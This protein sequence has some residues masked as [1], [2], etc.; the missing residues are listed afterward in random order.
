MIEERTPQGAKARA[1]ILAALV[2]AGYPRA[3]PAVLQPADVFL[4]MAGEDIRG[5][6]FLTTDPS[7]TEFCLRPEFTIP[8][9]RDYLASPQAGRAASFSY[10]GSVF[11]QRPGAPPETAQA[12]LEDFGRG[13]REAAD[14][15]I[16]W[17]TL[18]AAKAGG[19]GDALDLRIGDTGLFNALLEALDLPPAWLRRIRK[20][21]MRGDPLADTLDGR[22]SDAAPAHAG[23][24]AALTGSDRSNARALVED[25]L[26]IAG[27][28][29][30]GGRTAGEI[31][32]RFLEQAAM[33][34]DMGVSPEKR[35]ILE[36]F[37][38]IA[39]E[40]DA[41]LAAMRA[42]ARE[43]G[44]DLS[45]AFNVFEQRLG[46]I[47]THRIDLD[48]LAFAAR[49]GRNLDYYTGFVFEAYDPASADTR[50]VLGGG[51]Y[52]RL[53]RSLGAGQDIP[54]VGAAIWCDRLGKGAS[55]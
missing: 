38:A 25:L 36:R 46:F 54:A 15:D 30:V 5:R 49:F 13:D 4:D 47:A 1:N 2:A 26:S 44:L 14:A 19:G 32:D 50:P 23:V 10:L 31:A 48:K 52:D 53:L 11:R 9:C 55:R 42:L 16:L 40:P 28:V 29:S 12:G 35:G 22:A 8:V 27:I 39:G 43:T 7:G 51:R 21:H 17:R 3:E 24:L 45:R 18:E 20:G 41:S 33:R 37:L 6:I 34:A